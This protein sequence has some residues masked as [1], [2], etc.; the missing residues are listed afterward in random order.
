MRFKSSKG[1]FIFFNFVC[2]T[3]K[4]S[5]K[6][7]FLLYILYMYIHEYGHLS[8]HDFSSYHIVEHWRLRQA[9]ADV[10]TRQSFCCSHTQSMDVN[11]ESD[12]NV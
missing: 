5:D 4:Y 12:Q 6:M 1:S 2:D 9:W 3:L 10:Q 8:T 11:E 7:M